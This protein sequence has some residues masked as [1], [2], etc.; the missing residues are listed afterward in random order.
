MLPNDILQTIINTLLIK[1][2]LNFRITN[3]E[4]K[5]ITEKYNPSYMIFIKKSLYYKK[6]IFPNISS[7]CIRGLKNLTYTDFIY[8]YNIETLDMSLCYQKEIIKYIFP[9]FI[10]IKKLLLENCESFLEYINFTD[11]E[12]DYLRNLETL[13]IN[14][15]HVI[16]DKGL[17]KLKNIR[18]LNIQNCKNITNAGLSNLVTLETLCVNNVNNLPLTDDVFKN[19]TNLKKLELYFNN[20]TDNGI[21]YNNITDNGILYLTNIRELKLTSTYDI[22]CKDF[23]KLKNLVELTLICTT[24]TDDDLIYLKNIKKLVLYF[25]KINGKGL[26][27][28]TNIETLEISSSNIT[29]EYITNIY[30]LKKL[31]QISIFKCY[32]ISERMMNELKIK[33]GDKLILSDLS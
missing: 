25:S 28:L 1:D 20:I 7:V 33:F 22:K 11:N 18:E 2:V 29:D 8:L 13:I 26:S 16:T 19:L 14:D 23:D 10:K 32:L 15:N 27:H 21:Y 12:F 4:N 3:K 31:K 30:T 24:I 6:K 17:Q 5:K 9:N